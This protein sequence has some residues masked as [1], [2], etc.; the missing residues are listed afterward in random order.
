MTLT[1]KF[2]IAFDHEPNARQFLAGTDQLLWTKFVVWRPLPSESQRRSFSV[3]RKTFNTPGKRKEKKPVE[4]TA[5]MV[6]TENLEG[7][8]SCRNVDNL[9]WLQNLDIRVVLWD[10]IWRNT[11]I[12][13][14]ARK[15]IPTL[16]HVRREETIVQAHTWVPTRAV[17]RNTQN[18]IWINSVAIL[19]ACGGR[20]NRCHCRQTFI[21]S[22]C[23][24]CNSVTSD[25]LQ[26]N[27]KVSV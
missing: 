10:V 19:Q 22:I 12:C 11:E 5:Y 6:R 21:C 7:R 2:V 16:H 25:Y 18:L 9:T 1:K 4:F 3:A 15:L 14:Q 17:D 24:T 27:R 20:R 8:T 23:Y 26:K 13:C